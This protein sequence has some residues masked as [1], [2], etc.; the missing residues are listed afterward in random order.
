MVQLIRLRKLLRLLDDVECLLTRSYVD[1]RSFFEFLVATPGTLPC[2]LV[3]I[4]SD[5]AASFMLKFKA[6]R[7]STTKI[8]F[9]I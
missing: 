7:L 4:I 5:I 8:S 9:I 6:L 2:P 1:T 3:P